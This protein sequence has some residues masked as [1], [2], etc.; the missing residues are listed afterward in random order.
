MKR[1]SIISGLVPALALSGPAV[2]YA[3]VFLSTEQAK[4]LL[5]PGEQL[6][7]A[8]ITLTSAQQKAISKA[9]GVRVRSDSVQVWRSSGGGWLITD[10]VIG[11]HE[12]ID[13]ALALKADGSVKGVEIMTYR[14][15]YGGEVKNPKWRAQFTGKTSHEPVQI[16]K[17][18]KN[19]S[20]A[21]LS[22]VHITDGVRRLLFTW[23]IALQPL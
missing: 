22:S 1:R 5:F 7:P 10:N 6:A 18:I 20:G 19:I 3:E 9:S 11:K 8:H 16:D 2:L 17:D 14:E 13:F 15:T 21:T 23:A 4:A 12:F